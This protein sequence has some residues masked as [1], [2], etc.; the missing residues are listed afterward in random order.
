[1]IWALGIYSF[2]VGV[3]FVLAL[4]YSTQPD[5]SP[6]TA[7]ESAKIALLWPVILIAALVAYFSNDED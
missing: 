7:L 4:R 6:S 3:S 5:G 2:G 1:M